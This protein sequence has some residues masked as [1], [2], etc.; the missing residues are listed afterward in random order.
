MEL[1]S[2]DESKD[3]SEELQSISLNEKSGD[4][5]YKMK[6]EKSSN[7][8][9]LERRSFR[10]SLMSTFTALAVVLGYMLAFLPNVEVFTLMLF[11]AGFIMG[12]RDGGI[13]GLMSSFIFCFF[14]PLGTSPLPL[15][16]LQLTFYSSVGLLGGIMGSVLDSRNFFDPSE[17]LYVLPVMAILGTIVGILTFLY[18]VLSTVVLALS[19]FGTMDAFWPNYL[20]GL[21][22]TIVHLIGNILLF[23][24]VLPALIQLLYK[25]LDVPSDVSR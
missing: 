10:I 24:F 3:Q 20:I 21:P 9:W 16:M 14:N 17:D 15:L 22:F 8:H 4:S 23:V 19:V 12:K 6:K 11:L 13:I 7:G 2:Q 1:V 25:I 18:D 5:I